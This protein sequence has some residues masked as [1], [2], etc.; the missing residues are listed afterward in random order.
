MLLF[1]YNPPLTSSLSQYLSANDAA[2]C[3]FNYCTSEK[4]DD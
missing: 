1:Q 2:P 3:L 4:H